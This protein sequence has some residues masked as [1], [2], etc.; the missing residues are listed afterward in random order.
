MHDINRLLNETAAKERA[1]DEELEELF[2]HRS[3]LERSVSSLNASTSQVLDRVEDDAEQLAG[4][5]HNTSEVSERV[6]KKIRELDTAQSRIHDTLSRIRVVVDRTQAID[7]VKQAMASEDYESAAQF[8]KDF[9]DLDLQPAMMQDQVEG[10]QA[11]QQHKVLLESKQQLERIV[12]S[13]LQQASSSHNQA[14]V[15]RFTRLYAPLGLKD[16]GMDMFTEYLQQGI[17]TAAEESHTALVEN[18]GK[19]TDFVSALTEI[20]RGIAEALEPNER[21]VTEVFGTDAF[22]DFAARL[23][24]ECDTHGSRLLQRFMQVRRLPQLMRATLAASAPRRL[25]KDGAAPDAAVGV[26]P[27]Q[28]EESLGEVLLLCQRSEEYSQYLLGMLCRQPP[29]ASP[30]AAAAG[31]PAAAVKPLGSSVRENAFRSGP[32]CTAVRELV[33]CY[34]HLEEYCLEHNVAKAQKIDEWTAEVLTTSVV[35]DTFFIL[36]KCGARALATGNLQCVCAILGQLNSM[37]AAHLRAGLEHKWK[38]AALKLV[39]SLPPAS[40]SQDPSAVTSASMEAAE[41]AAVLNNASMSAVYVGKLLPELEAG[42]LAVFSAPSDRDRVTSVLADLAKTASDFHVIASKGLDLLANGILPRLR[43]IMDAVPS[44][45]LSEAEYAAREVEDAWVHELLS[46][47]IGCLRWLQPIFTPENY[48]SLVATVLEKVVERLEA[49]VA[50]KRFNQLGGLQLDRDVRTAV[51]TLGEVTQRTVRDKWARLS[52]M[53]TI[54]SLET[55]EELLDY[56]ASGN[57]R[58]SPAQARQVLAQRADFDEPS[59]VALDL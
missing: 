59:I 1:I 23:H 8:V 22:P 58:L 40:S 21:F 24:A 47:L 53:A 38:A 37:L 57:W 20:F 14:D 44:Y 17:R 49:V 25:A 36:Q 7:G 41:A 19:G 31:R 43:P 2:T 54:L 3:Q 9:L 39:Q 13:K 55:C 5:V 28:V 29:L 35:D 18:A 30:T 46:A 27:R 52:Q 48:D 12:A 42:A 56:W 10:T 6:S 50:G 34:T 16:K 4:S 45:E 32:F 15:V 11:E 33:S 26:D 51:A